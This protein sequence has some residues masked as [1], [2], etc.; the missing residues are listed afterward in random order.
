MSDDDF[1]LN[2]KA[3]DGLLKALKNN[4][5]R[6]RVGILGSSGKNTRNNFQVPGGRSVNAT[7]G[8]APKYKFDVETNAAV[9]ALHEFG[10]SKLPM[11]SFLRMPIT[12]KLSGEL[13][14]SKAF[15]EDALKEVVK[16]GTMLA[17][18]YDLAALA[19]K[20]VSDAF[21]TGGFGKWP[22]TKRE[23]NTGQTL[24]DTQQLR[25]S[26]TSEVK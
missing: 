20:I 2:T 14:N 26:I 11:R 3:L 10:T 15:T 22:K 8:N 23:N 12:E 7:K 13:E 4:M 5:S 6:V 17:W 24:V 16:Q 21:D 19:E 25:N 18:L 9:G 1:D